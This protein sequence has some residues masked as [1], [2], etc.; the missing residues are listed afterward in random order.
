M[1]DELGPWNPLDLTEI[2]RLFEACPARWWVSGGVALELH[3]GR[4][5]RAHQDSDVSILRS[6]TSVLRDVLVGWD[7]EV[8]ASGELTPWDGS[9]PSVLANQNNM[10]CREAEDQPWC[11]DVTISDGDQDCWIYRRDRDLRVPWEEALLRSERG[12]PYLAPDL[13]L[14]FKSKNNRPKDDHD[15]AEVIPLLDP[16]RQL[17]LRDLLPP[18]HPW[19]VLIA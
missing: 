14:L 12:I 6:D 8:A 13:Q 10:W 19:Q 16:A 1:P 4:S 15:A 2:V 7:I 11:L 5:W 9:M 18:D 17:R 3:L